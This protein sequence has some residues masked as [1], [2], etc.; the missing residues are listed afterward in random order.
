MKTHS[1]LM[2]DAREIL[3]DTAGR[4]PEYAEVIN[5]TGIEWNSRLRT[6]AGRGSSY[7]KRIQLSSVIFDHEQ[8]QDSFRNTVLH[9][10]AHVL[11]GCEHHHNYVWRMVA[12]RIGCNAQRTH[13]MAVKRRPGGTATCLRCGQ[14]MKLGPVQYG[15]H[16]A[17]VRKGGQGYSHR[18]CPRARSFS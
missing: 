12:R 3:R 2:R 14:D 11:A 18:R 16:M 8:N 7:L 10:L 17:I 13:R 15:R 9:E 1:E 4:Y 5:S 6:T